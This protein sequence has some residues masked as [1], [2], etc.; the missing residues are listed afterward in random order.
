M[1]TSANGRDGG[2]KMTLKVLESHIITSILASVFSAIGVGVF[3]YFNTNYTLANHTD[4][5][6]NLESRVS[7]VE[8]NL[9]DMKTDIATLKGD[10]GYLKTDMNDIKQTQKQMQEDVKEIY[11][12]VLTLKNK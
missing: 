1:T 12:I 10:V 11:K 4:K 2:K 9:G 3:F 8:Q 7:K 5:L 6:N